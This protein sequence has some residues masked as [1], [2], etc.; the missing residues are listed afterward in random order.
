MVTNVLMLIFIVALAQGVV[1]GLEINCGC[2]GAVAGNEAGDLWL[3]V[4]RDVGLLAPGLH[5]V[6]A[7][8]G[9]FS[10]DAVLRRGS[11]DGA[12]EI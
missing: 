8:I 1:R 5:I 9:R 4:L 3:D 12:Y 7:P 6:L 11:G 10:V 2:F